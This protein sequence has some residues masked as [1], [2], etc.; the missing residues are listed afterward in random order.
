MQKLISFCVTCRNRLWQIKKTLPENIDLINDSHEMVLV[1]YGSTDGLSE[2]V[3]SNF[4]SHIENKKMIF[5]EVKNEVRWNVARAK[6]LAHRLASGEYL[7][8]L[9]ADNFLTLSDIKVIGKAHELGLHSHQ[10]S[11]SWE[12]GSFGRIGVPKRVFED[13]GGYDETLLPMG[14]Q[15]IDIL[16]RLFIAQKKK[17]ANLGSPALVAIKNSITDKTKEMTLSLDQNEDAEKIYAEVNGINLAI[18]KL[19]LQTEGPV[20]MGGG[21]SYRGLLNGKLVTINGFNEVRYEPQ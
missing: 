11:M 17:R 16:N 21:F 5:F 14:G 12:D 7:F 4:K 2:W 20:R 9:D 8:N 3:W 6:N 13:I 15:D 1:D 10:W 19:K 18:C